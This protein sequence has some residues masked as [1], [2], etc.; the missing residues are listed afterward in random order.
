MSRKP[1]PCSTCGKPCQIGRGSL[2]Q[3]TC[4]PCRRAAIKPKRPAAAGTPAVCRKCGSCFVR[5]AANQ[6][7]CRMPCRRPSTPPS[8]ARRAR[9]R[10]LYGVEHQRLRRELRPLFV[11]TPCHL[12]GEVMDDE[13]AMHLDH[14]PDTLQYRGF[15]H[16]SCNILDGARRGQARLRAKKLA[17]GRWAA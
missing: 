15:A 2:P 7:Y 3:P 14:D 5:D 4:L 11:G 12:C 9:D 8:P 6:T 10:V 1:V 17:R 16:A 13:K